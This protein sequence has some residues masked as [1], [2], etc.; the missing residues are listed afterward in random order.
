MAKDPVCGMYVDEKKAKLSTEQEGLTYYFC[1]ENCLKEFLRPQAEMRKLK[2]VAAFSIALGALTLLFEYFYPVRP[3]GIS[4]YI[5]LFLLATPVQFVGG[6]RF[7]KGTLDAIKAR[8]ANMDSLIA[9]GTSAAW[10]YSTIFTFQGIFWPRIFPSVTTGGPEVYF[11]ESGLIIGFILLGRYMEH[12]VKG[13]ASNAIRRLV[14]LQPKMAKVVREGNETEIPVEEVKVGDIVVIR[15]GE[16][17]PVD[18]IIMD[19]SSAI[20]QSMITGESIPVD[21]KKGDEVIGATI[22]KSG[23]LR[24]KTTKVGSDTALSQIVMMVQE[25]IAQ[26]AP[27]QRLADVVSSYFVPAVV[28]ISIVSFLF[29]Y[30]VAGLPFAAALTTLIAVLIIACPCALGIATPAAIM[31]GAGKGAQ[32]GILIKSGEYLEKARKI[33]TIV[34]DKTGTLTKGEPEVTDIIVTNSKENIL[35]YAATA[36]SGSEHPLGQAIVKHAKA[37]NIRIGEP[38]NFKAIAGHGISASYRGKKVLLGNRK[39]MTKNRIDTE[40]V[41]KNVQKLEEDGKTVM[42]IAINKKLAGFIAVADTLKENSSEAVK[43]LELMGIDVIMITGDNPRT[44]NAISKKVEI[45]RVLAEVLPQDKAKEIK[46]L[47]KEGRIVAMVGDGINDAPALAQ[48]DVGIAIGAGTDIAKETG[49]I[50]LIKNDLRDVVG[51]IKLSKKTVRKMKENLFWAFVYNVAL[52]PV[53]AGMLYPFSGIML[54]P[55][56]AAIAMALSSITVVTNSL[57]LAK[58]RL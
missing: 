43:K 18:G 12:L 36:E 32:N 4:N 1:S 8:Q 46:K 55:I 45:K 31:I 30:Y 16:K 29:W 37:K 47:Q 20:D 24:I 33:N 6:W 3:F 35:L 10:L 23:L 50:V 13:R 48:A 22:N 44:A 52:I 58:Y 14:D 49:G 34:F 41:E 42:F 17:I 26:R 40:R 39:L 27:M 15:P 38:K 53:A 5:L 57:L 19:G 25:A 54:N 2:Y 9:I 28:V 21:R 11:T 7:Y 56:Y 51:A